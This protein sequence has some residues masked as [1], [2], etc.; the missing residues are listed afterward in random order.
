MISPTTI[1]AKE[2]EGTIS[3]EGE[4]HNPGKIEWKENRVAKDYINLSGGLTAF[5]DKKHIIYVAPYG[6]AVKIK[7][8]SNRYILPG[9]KIIVNQKP[10]N[11]LNARPDRFQQFSSLVTSFVTIAILANTV[12]NAN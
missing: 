12:N 3:I 1:I 11:E 4:V 5:G 2:F 8:K 6:E 10:L 9:S 7:N